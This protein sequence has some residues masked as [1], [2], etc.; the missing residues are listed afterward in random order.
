MSF[1]ASAR[2][3]RISALMS[4]VWDGP[5]TQLEDDEI[6][7]YFSR[8]CRAACGAC[9]GAVWLR[10]VSA[11]GKIP[12]GTTFSDNTSAVCGSAAPCCER[13]LKTAQ[14]VR[15]WAAVSLAHICAGTAP[16][17]RWDCR[18]SAPGLAHMCAHDSN[19]WEGVAT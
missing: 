7:A 19:R 2:P 9:T 1:A 13:V 10:G 17:L 14:D 5:L 4:L 11:L 15:A 16:H 6:A 8:P 18:T 3:M 12:D